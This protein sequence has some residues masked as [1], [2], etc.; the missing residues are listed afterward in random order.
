MTTYL[1]AGFISKQPGL[2]AIKYKTL[3]D[4]KKK[5]LGE[6]SSIPH[7]HFLA[8][9]ISVCCLLCFYVQVNF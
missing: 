7:F 3:G 2:K 4:N 5:H 1:L 6:L 9:N 8:R